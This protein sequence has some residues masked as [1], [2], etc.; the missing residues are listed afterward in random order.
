MFPKK[1]RSG[2]QSLRIL[3]I[4]VIVVEEFWLLAFFPLPNVQVVEFLTLAELDGDQK[5]FIPVPMNTHTTTRIFGLRR[6]S[7]VGPVSRKKIRL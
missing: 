7:V 3:S 1:E 2:E 5:V 4:Q 6:V